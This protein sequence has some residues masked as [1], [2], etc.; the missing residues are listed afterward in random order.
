VEGPGIHHHG[1]DTAYCPGKG[2]R[3]CDLEGSGGG[4]LAP[5]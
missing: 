3:G 2:V 4:F 1:A 5:M